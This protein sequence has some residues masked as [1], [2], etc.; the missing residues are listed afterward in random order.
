MI[1]V[2]SH[3]FPYSSVTVLSLSSGHH[4]AVL[5]RCD[6]TLPFLLSTVTSH[7]LSDGCDVTTN[8][9]PHTP[10]RPPMVG[11]FYA[12]SYLY[13]GA[14]G[15]LSTVLAGVLLSYLAG[16][17]VG[18]GGTFRVGGR[19]GAAPRCSL[20]PLC[21]PP[22]GPTKRAQLPPGVLWWDITKQTSSVSPAGGTAPSG[23]CPT[24]VT[25]LRPPHPT[26]NTPPTFCSHVPSP[27]VCRDRQG[28]PC[29]E[30]PPVLLGLGVQARG[31]PQHRGVTEQLLQESHV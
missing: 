19:E 31:P 1:T 22:A 8:T 6:V 11:D 25:A 24:K 13:Y 27:Q 23:G 21:C 29:P 26:Q 3:R 16:E 10:R 17:P 20:S 2:T 14:L 28:G 4:T 9:P 18:T 7:C 15:T 12:I 5:A 30:A